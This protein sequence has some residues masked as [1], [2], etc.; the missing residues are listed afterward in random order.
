[1][2]PPLVARVV[3]DLAVRTLPA[4]HRER[5]ALEFYADLFG[6]PRKDQRRQAFS[7]L[8]HIQQLAWALGESAADLERRPPRRRDLRCVFHLH[9]YVRRHILHP[10]DAVHFYLECTRCQ[11]V[12]SLPDPRTAGWAGAG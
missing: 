2:Q 1:L 7:V 9:H 10:E 4:E 3:V 5:Y 12:R 8:I 11:S 6:L